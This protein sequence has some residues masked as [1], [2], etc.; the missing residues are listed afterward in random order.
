MSCSAT[1]GPTRQIGGAP[2]LDPPVAFGS[3]EA[4]Q[5]LDPELRPTLRQHDLDG[6]ID[7]GVDDRRAQHRM[8][9]RYFAPGFTE[10]VDIE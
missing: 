8:T 4:G 3:V 7:P 10:Q 1:A 9:P 6:T 2:L 5:I